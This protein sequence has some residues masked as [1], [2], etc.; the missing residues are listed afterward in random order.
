MSIYNNY[1]NEI[2]ERKGQGLHPKPIDG[3]E[4]LNE[5]IA[6]IKD[7]NNQYREDSLNFFIYNV[8]PGTT[9][10]ASVKAEFLKEI[11]LGESVLKE[12]S[13]A[14]AFEQLSHMKGGPSV[15]VLLDLALGKNDNIAR[16]ASKVLK[17][18]FFETEAFKTL[19]SKVILLKL[20]VSDK[21]STNARLGIHYTKQTTAPGVSLIDNASASVPDKA[22][23][24]IILIS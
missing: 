23:L 15:K 10:A 22:E 6:Q 11:I 1:I 19:A 17:D 24:F 9:S 14:F 3:D 16:E 20:D 5:I 18:S 4:L 12:I 7:S 2:E 13:P 21:Q 8:L